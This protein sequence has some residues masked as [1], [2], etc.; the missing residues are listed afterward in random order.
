M[1]TPAKKMTAAAFAAVLALGGTACSDEDN[2]G[3]TG[4]EETEQLEENV[5]QGADEVEQQLDEG[6]EEPQEGQQ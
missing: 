5:G 6:A 3:S 2:D 1:N 4:D